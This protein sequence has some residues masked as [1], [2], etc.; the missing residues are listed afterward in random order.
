MVWV[1]PVR[2]K[3]FLFEEIRDPLNSLARNPSSSCDLSHGRR[4][5]FDEIEYDPASERLVASRGQRFTRS[6]EQSP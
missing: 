4:L 1:H 5:V 6:G 2:D 3:A